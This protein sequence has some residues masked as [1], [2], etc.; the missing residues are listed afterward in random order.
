[1][2]LEKIFAYGHENISCTH[3]STIEITKE[4]SI[5]QKGTCILG[6]KA[7]KACYDLN[8]AIKKKIRQGMRFLVIIKIDEICDSFYGYG[9]P[10]LTLLND[11]EM[12]FRKSNFICDRT[13]LIRCS[14][15]SN[16]LNSKLINKI[17]DQKRR[18]SI[19]FTNDDF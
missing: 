12:V 11:H 6:V 9:D 16:E 18:F 19:L 10:N 17:K 8:D 13:V 15:A 7:T 2:I 5:T 3:H 1:M 4:S 14:K